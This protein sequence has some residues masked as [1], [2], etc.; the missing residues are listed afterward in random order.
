[1]LPNLVG[2]WDVC[3]GVQSRKAPSP[4]RIVRLPVRVRVSRWSLVL[5]RRLPHIG[6]QPLFCQGFGLAPEALQI[7]YVD[8]LDSA[9]IQ[10]IYSIPYT[11][12]FE[13]SFSVVPK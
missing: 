2:E 4:G 3:Y 6:P 1:M 9:L 7:L 11:V 13:A 12:R 5:S 10:L 8:A